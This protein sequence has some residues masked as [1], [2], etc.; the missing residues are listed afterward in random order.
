MTSAMSINF[1]MLAF[2][3]KILKGALL[4]NILSLLIIAIL[5]IS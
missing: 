2:G 5:L 4:C 1:K 3:N